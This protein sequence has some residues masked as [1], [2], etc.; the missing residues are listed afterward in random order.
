MHA[1][2]D[3]SAAGESVLLALVALFLLASSFATWWM[4][5]APPW[6]FSYLIWLGLIGLIAVLGRRLGRYDL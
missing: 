6:Y 4:Q 1:V 2:H 3:Y 5:L